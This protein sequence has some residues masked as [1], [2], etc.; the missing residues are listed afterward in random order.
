MTP[1]RN[2]SI[3]ELSKRG[4]DLLR[5]RM[6]WEAEKHFRDALALDN[7]NKYVLVGLGNLY[8]AL[9]KFPDAISFYD[10]ALTQDPANKFALRGIGD[11]YRGQEQ[12]GEAIPYWLRYL[13]HSPSDAQVMARLADSYMKLNNTAEAEVFCAKALQYGAQDKAALLGVGLL[14]YKIGENTQALSCFEQLISLDGM[15]LKALLMAGELHQ[16]LVNYEPAARYYKRALDISPENPVAL[17]GLANC[18]RGQKDHT[19]GSLWWAKALEKDPNNQRLNTRAGDA[20]F[21]TGNLEE[22]EQHFQRSLQVGFDPYALLGL[23]RIHRSRDQLE[24]AQACCQKVLE[25]I[26]DHPRAL[27]ELAKIQETLVGEK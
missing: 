17:Y 10:K 6:F 18:S 4:Y 5:K 26:P 24:D 7:H 15:H 25:R 3:V 19:E 27:E 16:L 21:N 2:Q 12:P 9:R 22:A 11:A 1:T 8:S 14:Y 23:S 20:L 13:E